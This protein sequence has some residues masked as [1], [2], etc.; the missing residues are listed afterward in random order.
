MNC[1]TCRV[2]IPESCYLDGNEKDDIHRG[3]FRCP[4]CHASHIR[5]PAGH[6]PDGSPLFEFRLWGH[7]VT[8]R[9]LHKVEE[10]A[11]PKA[12]CA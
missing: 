4:W 6:R 10:K 12:V 7:P 3:V 11:G 1:L 9:R 8:S 5:R 2:E